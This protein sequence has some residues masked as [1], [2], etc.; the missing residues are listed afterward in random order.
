MKKKATSLSAVFAVFFLAASTVCVM[1]VSAGAAEVGYRKLMLGDSREKVRDIIKKNFEGEY[2]VTNESENALALRKMVVDKTALLIELIFDHKSILYK[3]NV[4][5]RKIPG[6]PDPDEV[7]KVI[8]E[9]YGAPS[10][11]E[12][13]NTLDLIAHWYPDNGRYEI[14]FHNISSWDKFD[15]QYTDTLLEKQK[16]RYDTEKNRKPVKKELDF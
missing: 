12:I 11:R 10:K 4:K 5:I 8:E 9:K 3:I 14:F 7:V 13:T 1:A 15:V 16:E 6:N 2:K